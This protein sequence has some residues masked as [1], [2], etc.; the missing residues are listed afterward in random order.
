MQILSKE[1]SKVLAEQHGWSLTTAEGY[2]DGE[3]CRRRGKVPPAHVLV[4]M[5]EY[6]EGFRAGFYSR[7]PDST[8]ASRPLPTGAPAAGPVAGNEDFTP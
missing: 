2:V 8:R 5:D 3:A 4:G 1:K 7:I 6:S